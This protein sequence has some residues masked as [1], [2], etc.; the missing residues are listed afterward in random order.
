ML[1][2]GASMTE[3]ARAQ[4]VHV[5][6]VFKWQR[7]YQWG[8]LIE[9]CA[10]RIPV[11]VSSVEEAADESEEAQAA[12]SG[13]TIPIDFPRRTRISEVRGKQRVRRA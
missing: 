7:E 8:E 3:M 10:E 12:S 9:P 11:T 5:N 2:P 13:G 1:E 6:R 4:G